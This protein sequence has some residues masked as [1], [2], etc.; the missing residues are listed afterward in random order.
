MNFA[1]IA[2]NWGWIRLIALWL[3][4]FIN[5]VCGIYCCFKYLFLDLTRLGGNA[6]AA[7][8]Q[9][10]SLSSLIFVSSFVIWLDIIVALLVYI[11]KRTGIKPWQMPQ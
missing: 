10:Q 3:L 8:Q 1:P 4:Y 2:N 6:Y 7:L 5:I 11:T 9:A